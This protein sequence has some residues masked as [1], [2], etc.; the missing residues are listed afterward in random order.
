MDKI[1][2]VVELGDRRLV[3]KKKKKKKG[4]NNGDMYIQ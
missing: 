1:T 2:K 3:S 4:I